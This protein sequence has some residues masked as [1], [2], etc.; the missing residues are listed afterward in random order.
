[1][2]SQKREDAVIPYY[3]IAI[4]NEPYNFTGGERKIERD[5]V[6]LK[7]M[8]KRAD[9]Y[10][11]KLT[12][13][14][15]AQW[16]DYIS[17][18]P[19]RLAALESWEKQGHEIA[20]HHHHIYFRNWDGYTDYPREQVMELRVQLGKRQNK[21][22][23]TLQEYINKLK[24]INP[25]IR[26]G[27]LSDELDKRTLPDEIIYDTCSGFANFGEPGRIIEDDAIPEK[28]KNEYIT[29]GNYKKIERKWLTHYYIATH[30]GQEAARS[31]FSSMHSGVYGV[32]THS[33]KGEAEHYSTFLEFLHS[34]D[35]AGTKSRTVSEIIEQK[36]LPEVRIA[37]ELLGSGL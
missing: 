3:F 18:N 29:A 7:Q 4:H 15:A 28:G 17:Q 9:E 5:Y 25:N 23:G 36:L 27:C 20:A 26:S 13:M 2:H 1:M 19:Q 8:I 30:E 12:L 14:F 6:V 24:K 10:N 32:V 31:V 37:D 21:Y 11:V 33:F 16:A 35:S 22:C 34:K